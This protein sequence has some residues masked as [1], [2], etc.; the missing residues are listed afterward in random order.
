MTVT[1]EDRDAMAKILNIM[2]GRAPAPV[3]RPPSVGAIDVE[4]A[5]PGQVTNSDINALAAVMNRLNNISDFQSNNT[6]IML[7]ESQQ[8]TETTEALQTERNSAGVKVGRYQI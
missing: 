6:D 3:V 4:L 2:E 8:P 1:S 7:S 5:G